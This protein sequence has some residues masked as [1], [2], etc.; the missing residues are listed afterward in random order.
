VIQVAPRSKKIHEEHE[1]INIEDQSK[2]VPPI[3]I[4]SGHSNVEITTLTSINHIDRPIG[5]NNETHIS[6]Q[7]DDLSN[8]ILEEDQH[9]DDDIEGVIDEPEP[10][11]T[12]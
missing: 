3:Y 12:M 9:H 7:N 5:F 8:A 4:D 2:A 6:T 11:M 10:N 1:L